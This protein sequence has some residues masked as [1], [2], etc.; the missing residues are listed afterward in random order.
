MAAGETTGETA[1]AFPVV[2]RGVV[3]NVGSTELLSSASINLKYLS[4]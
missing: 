3:L 4:Q 1:V 2:A